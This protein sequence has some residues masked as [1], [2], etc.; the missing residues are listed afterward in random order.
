MCVA[1]NNNNNNNNNNNKKAFRE[2]AVELHR[3]PYI[4]IFVCVCVC[5]KSPLQGYTGLNRDR[6]PGSYFHLSLQKSPL[7]FF[8]FLLAQLIL[9]IKSASCSF[10][11]QLVIKSKTPFVC[12]CS[13]LIGCC[14]DR[15]STP[16][17]SIFNII[18]TLN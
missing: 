17:I 10:N 6:C 11:L 9:T 5:V 3:P 7:F 12:R 13:A 14:L 2:F 4:Y 15:G 16:Y 8:F 1:L 18:S